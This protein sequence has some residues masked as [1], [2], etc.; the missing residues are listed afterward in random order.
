MRIA[1]VQLKVQPNRRTTNLQAALDAIDA[2]AK[3]DPAPDLILLPAFA[4][5]LD[6]A[7]GRNDPCEYVEGQATAACGL[8]ARSW[9]LF[10]AF[11]MAEKGGK[12]P[13]L[14]T[15]LL[16]RDGDVRLAQRQMFLHESTSD[17]F[18]PGKTLSVANILLGRIGLLTGD[19]WLNPRAWDHMVQSSAQ[20]VVGSACCL[21]SAGKDTDPQ[22]TRSPIAEQARRTNLW[23]AVA[24]ATTGDQS[25]SPGLSTIINNQGEIIAAAPPGEAVTLWAEINL[26]E[27]E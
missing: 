4:D 6:S 26:P 23:C 21:R 11:G 1:V 15:V 18:Q 14:T 2:A 25:N 5:V 9:G 19:D 17:F 8:R 24:D 13:Y 20:L 10:I 22:A 3:T 16:D 12:R 7:A 27:Q